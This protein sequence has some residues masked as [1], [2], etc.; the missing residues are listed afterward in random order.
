MPEYEDL[1]I[2]RH[3]LKRQE[4]HILHILYSKREK[5]RAKTGVES[6]NKHW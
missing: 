4:G 2:E 5:R 3:E 1:E 6:I